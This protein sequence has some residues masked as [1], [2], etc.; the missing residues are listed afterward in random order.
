MP[1]IKSR[2]LRYPVE[3]I[4]V[5]S[6]ARMATRYMDRYLR[7]KGWVMEADGKW[8]PCVDVYD[9]PE[10]F[11]IRVELPDVKAEDIDVTL[12]D[13]TINIDGERRP[14]DGY[15]REDIESSEFYYGNFSRSVTLPQDIK[16]DEIQA[17]LD[18]GVLEILVPKVRPEKSASRIAVKTK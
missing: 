4:A 11:S 17:N 9:R 6:L 5:T 12:S 15:D 14:P 13:R 3:A 10:D 18:N 7:G 2:L 8:A 16:Q 1:L